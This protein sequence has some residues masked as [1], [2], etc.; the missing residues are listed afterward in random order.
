MTTHSGNKPYKCTLCTDSFISKVVLNRH[1][2]FHGESAKVFRCE[3]CCK[4]LSTETSLKSHVQRLHN[5][6]VPCELCKKEFATREHLKEHLRTEH[7]PSICTVC[8]KTFTLPRYLKM[9]EKLHYDDETPRV[10][11]Q[12]CS[13]YLGVKNIKSHVY[14][15]HL[16]QFE[17]WC[18]VNPTL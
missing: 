8:N 10:Q 5:S 12:V 11:C 9:H 1:M 13:K 7:K 2:R 3:F 18:H 17:A 16:N 15:K 14:R 6:T 4:E